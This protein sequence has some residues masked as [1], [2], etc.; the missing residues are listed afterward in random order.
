MGIDRPDVRFVVHASLPK[1]VEQY[2]Q[3]TG[4]A[5]RDGLPSECVL[6]YAGSDFH[7]WKNL[8]ERSA[9][10]AE[11]E[12]NPSAGADLDSSI[13]RLEELWNYANSTRCR[14]RA[15][16]EH[17]GGEYE[18]AEGGCGACDVCLGE[19][20]VVDDAQVVAQTILSCVVRC[21]QRF[22]AAHVADVLR[23][24][25]TE[26][27]RRVGHQKLSTHGL[28]RSNTSREIRAWIDQLVAREHLAVTPG[29]YPTLYLTRS[30]VQV[31]KGEGEIS[32][33]LP[34]RPARSA[35][36]R[37][38]GIAAAADEGGPEPDAGLF[39]VL[40]KLRRDLAR[41]REVPPYILFNDRTL[42]LLA[43]HKPRTDVAFRAIKG[44]GDKKAVD[45][46]PIF[47]EAIGAYEDEE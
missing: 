30:G 12:G 21:D 16:V 20:Q 37:A 24:A 10:E 9:G 46:G 8:M 35:G 27:I 36:G 5:G 45:L 4:R 14:H 2:S 3:E 32:L 29:D 6:F 44:V 41:E 43:G 15:L 25:D 38:R 47:M 26:R 19:L 42:A 23:G 13:S 40:R 11:A 39:E 17:F 18:C 7:G 28:L 31:M 33:F 22:G 34:K 1:G